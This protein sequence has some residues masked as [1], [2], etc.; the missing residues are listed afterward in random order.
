MEHHQLSRQEQGKLAEELVSGLHS[1]PPQQL[2]DVIEDHTR[3]EY[4]QV[5]RDSSISIELT[6]ITG[7]EW[8]DRLSIPNHLSWRP[9]LIYRS[10]WVLSSQP[11]EFPESTFWRQPLPHFSLSASSIQSWDRHRRKPWLRCRFWVYYPV[12]V[13]SGK[14]P[15]LTAQQEETLPEVVEEVAFVHPVIATVDVADLPVEYSLSV[16]MYEDSDWSCG[17]SRYPSNE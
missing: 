13:K 14:K 4:R 10:E 9:D 5:V 12:E 1:E 2:I 16:T 6:E 7:Y 11:S 8:K 17:N 15:T 3:R